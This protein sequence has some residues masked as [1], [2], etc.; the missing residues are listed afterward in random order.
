MAD[1][2][3]EPIGPEVDEDEDDVEG[4]L[5]ASLFV[6]VDGEIELQIS[7]SHDSFKVFSFSYFIFSSIS[8][9]LRRRTSSKRLTL[10]FS[11]L[12][13]LRFIPSVDPP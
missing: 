7:R 4:E 9:R 11:R 12:K 2:S 8:R 3:S 10:S 5:F 1:S 13:C 6:D